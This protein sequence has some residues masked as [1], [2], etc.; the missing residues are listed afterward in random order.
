MCGMLCRLQ[1]GLHMAVTGSAAPAKRLPNP[2]L[3]MPLP[4]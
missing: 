3:H 1:V 4:G 2:I